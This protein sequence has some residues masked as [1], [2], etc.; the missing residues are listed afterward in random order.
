MTNNDKITRKC[1]R[2]KMSYTTSR[3][4]D[5]QYNWELNGFCSYTCDADQTDDWNYQDRYWKP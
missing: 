5:K 2:C 3:D 1:Y 4:E